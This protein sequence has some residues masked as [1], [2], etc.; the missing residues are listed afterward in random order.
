MENL[1]DLLPNNA[2]RGS[3]PRCHWLTHGTPEQVASRLTNLISPWGMVSPDDH[4]MP[5]GFINI[6]E[7]QLHL[8]NTLLPDEVRA[9]LA[10]WWLPPNAQNR[11]AP[12]FDIASTCTID[13]NDGILL[14]EA[15]A[16]STELESEE[17]G[18]ILGPNP[19]PGRI[20]SH[21]T[22]GTA[23]I[24]ACNG[25]SNSTGYPFNI[26]RDTHYQMSNRFAW[27]WKLTQLGYP[28]VLVYLGFLNADEMIDRGNPFTD[29]DDW[30][31]LVHGHSTPLFPEDIWT[32][33]MRIAN[34]SLIPLI[35][36]L[37]T[38]HD[39][40]WEEFEVF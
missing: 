31:A 30:K 37:E 16:H 36:S 13:G 2:Q 24:G 33:E 4:W 5:E 10:A 29:H 39:N 12:N 23:I 14:V 20:A 7:P 19:T 17:A 25:L 15:K 6:T 35:R 8:Q 3:K 1:M 22:I 28:V 38:P 40:P 18:R 34:K 32:S 11:R 21:V 9:Q 27:A 26:S